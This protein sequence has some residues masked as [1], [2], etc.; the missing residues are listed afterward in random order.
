MNNFNP[1]EKIIERIQQSLKKGESLSGLLT[2]ILQ[3]GRE[4]IYRRI[5]GDVPF[6]FEEVIK[7]SS[8][9]KFSIDSLVDLQRGNRSVF[10]INM[11]NPRAQLDDYS[12]ILASYTQLFSEMSKSPNSV[13]RY[14]LNTLPYTL[15]LGYPNLARFRYFRWMY[16]SH[17]SSKTRL[18][19]A[20]VVTP[21]KLLEVQKSFAAGSKYIS[22]TIMILG[23]N[24][25]SAIRRDIE[26]FFRLHFLTS[27]DV[28]VMRAELLEILELWEGYAIAGAFN[29]GKQVD[30]YLA[31]VDIEATYCLFEYEGGGFAHVRLYDASGVDSQAQEIRDV[32]RNWIDSF[33][34]Y[35]TLISQSGE[36]ERHRFFQAQRK[37]VEEMGQNIFQ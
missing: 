24:M 17:L 15:Y 36:M 20:D 35:S 29:T 7:I 21:P 33:R 18:K 23:Q 19:Y 1:N 13:A 2:D 31:N 27:D 9:L 30:I 6:T 8:E 34:R 4:S 11:L 12:A 10:E 22:R 25:F 16:Q 5:R 26:Y 14:A 3:L 37:I 32:Q 28:E